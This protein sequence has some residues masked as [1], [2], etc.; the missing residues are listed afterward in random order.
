MVKTALFTFATVGLLGADAFAPVAYRPQK[1]QARA[2]R[3]V[4]L[5]AA[6]D[7]DT[8]LAKLQHEYKILQERLLAVVVLQHD[9]EDAERVEEELLEIAA[10]ATRVLEH[11]Q[12]DIL[13]REAEHV[14]RAT[15]DNAWGEILEIETDQ[16]LAKHKMEAAEMLL[17]QLKRNE[18][19]LMATLETLREE[20]AA[21]DKEEEIHRQHRSFLDKVK[22]AIY[23][24]PDLL[25][26]LDP[27]I[28]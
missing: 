19:I 1:L 25:V 27:H 3:S 24:H 15:K 14:K 11:Q 17:K 6:A 18:A 5:Q 10:E 20:K 9:S 26:R 23:A 13:H 4:I 16:L 7:D 12:M 22:D 2:G 21:H 28:L 8:T